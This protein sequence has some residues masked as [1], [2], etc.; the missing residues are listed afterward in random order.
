MSAQ[1]SRMSP[2]RGGSNRFSTGLP[3]MTPIVSATWFTLAGVDRGNEEW[4]RR[5]VLR[6]RALPWTK[7][8]EV[9][10]DDRLERVVHAAEAD[11]VPLGG[12]LRDAVWRDWVGR[13]RLGRRELRARAVHRR[14]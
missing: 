8:V 10:E 13:C 11:A 12:E 2:A 4:H 9:A 5:R 1:E 6:L 3:R 14:R 7:D